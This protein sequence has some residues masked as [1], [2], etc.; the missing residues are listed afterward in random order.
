M[1]SKI[2]IVGVLIAVLY[3]EITGLST[4]GLVAP[5]YLALS[6]ND[7][8]PRSAEVSFAVGA[9]ARPE[10][11]WAPS[12]GAHGRRWQPMLAV[13]CRGRWAAGCGMHRG[14]QA[15]ESPFA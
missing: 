8:W 14:S 5:V 15:F 11:P 6:L 3:S 13:G 10:Q 9:S 4:G 1:Y 2:V 12:A 7:P